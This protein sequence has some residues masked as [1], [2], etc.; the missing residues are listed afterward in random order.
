MPGAIDVAGPKI[1]HQQL[2]TAKN[3]QLQKAVTPVAAVKESSLLIAMHSVIGGIEIQDQL[4]G[5][6]L[7]RGNE[8]FE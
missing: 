1:A 8:L 3:V 7:Q 6:L 4:G 2:L 5:S